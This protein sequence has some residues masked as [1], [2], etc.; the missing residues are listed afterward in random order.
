MYKM[1][2]IGLDANAKLIIINP[3]SSAKYIY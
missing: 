2:M 1:A 3:I